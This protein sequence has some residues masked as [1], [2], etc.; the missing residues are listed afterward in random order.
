MSE[1]P[2]SGPGQAAL[3]TSLLDR[4]PPARRARHLANLALRE[5]VHD[6]YHLAH[7]GEMAERLET[8]DL[9]VMLA[10]LERANP[11]LDEVREAK[12]DCRAMRGARR[13]LQNDPEGAFAE[14]AAVIEE[15][16][17]HAS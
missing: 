1:Q 17:D 9:D 14:W 5:H 16:P 13:F 7:F 10:E 2:P 15:V 8:L 11:D 6:R 3:V 12:S 4:L